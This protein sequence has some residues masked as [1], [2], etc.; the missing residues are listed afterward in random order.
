MENMGNENDKEVTTYIKVFLITLSYF[1]WSSELAIS[2][3]VKI[4]PA[5]FPRFL[6]HHGVES[7]ALIVI[8]LRTVKLIKQELGSIISEFRAIF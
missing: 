3:W 5:F 7:S 6:W 2:G 1:S 8:E 4:G